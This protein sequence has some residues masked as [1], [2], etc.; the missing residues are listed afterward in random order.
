MDE[1]ES[2]D[3]LLRPDEM[4]LRFAPGGLLLDGR[5]RSGDSLGHLRGSVEH[6]RLVAD[7]P[8]A[9]RDNFDRL[10]KVYLYGVLEY[11]LFTVAEDFAYLVL[12]GAFRM[13]FLT[14]YDFKVP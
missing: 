13:R 4:T 8:E 6:A 2:L 14:Y 10:R 11:E 5:L 9:V 7:V 1:P 3:D 12:E